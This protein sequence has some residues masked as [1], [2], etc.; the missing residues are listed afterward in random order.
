VFVPHWNASRA[1]QNSFT[2]E[3][4]PVGMC[5][6]NRQASAEPSQFILCQYVARTLGFDTQVRNAPQFAPFRFCTLWL[7]FVSE[8][9]LRRLETSL[10]A[11]FCTDTLPMENEARQGCSKKLTDNAKSMRNRRSDLCLANPPRRANLRLDAGR[12]R[13]MPQTA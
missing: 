5:R 7:I 6:E 3:S 11:W 9:K 8:L 12:R 10:T 13:S 2:P 4:K 1:S